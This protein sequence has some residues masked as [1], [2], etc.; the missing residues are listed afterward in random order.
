L[1]LLGGSL[2]FLGFLVPRYRRRKQA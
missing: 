2:A 1:A